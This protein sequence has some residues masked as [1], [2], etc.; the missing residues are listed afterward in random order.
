MLPSSV[1]LRL[2]PAARKQ[3]S[4]S[5]RMFYYPAV[6][7]DSPPVSGPAMMH[8][9][10]LLYAFLGFLF[11][12]GIID[13]RPTGKRDLEAPLAGASH[14]SGT[15]N[16][17]SH[18]ARS[19]IPQSLG[20]LLARRSLKSSRPGRL[21]GVS[22]PGGSLTRPKKKP[23]TIDET[24]S[25]AD[26]KGGGDEK[27]GNDEI[28]EGDEKDGGEED[29]AEKKDD[30]GKKDDAEKDEDIKEDK[31]KEK[32]KKPRPLK[33]AQ[34]KKLKA[35][36]EAEKKQQADEEKKK[37]EELKKQ[38]QQEKDAKRVKAQEEKDKEAQKVR[39][40]HF[41]DQKEQ[42]AA[43]GKEAE[44]KRAVAKAKVNVP[45]GVKATCGGS[46]V[47][48][49]AKLVEGI[50]DTLLR[51][52]ARKEKPGNQDDKEQPKKFGGVD[53]VASGGKLRDQ[54]TKCDTSKQLREWPIFSSNNIGDRFKPLEAGSQPGT[55]RVI[56]DED[57][58]YC[59]V[60]SHPSSKNGD[61]NSFVLCKGGN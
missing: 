48:K 51:L 59:G 58:Q 7:E 61:D 50:T 5:L 53:E 36:E 23:T 28:D 24:K 54:F 47:H 41:K 60:V 13:A 34:K 27:D 56:F 16:I 15:P 44:E 39:E 8:R 12:P 32:T 6:A 52:D 14:P 3:R 31:P 20:L 43:K 46:R 1:D 17:H 22:V 25:D 57:G 38:K 9:F 49:T 42:Q 35:Q 11:I 33:N 26:E 29:G 21:G 37:A 10:M 40:K 18:S 45:Q 2:I 55:D 4:P 30:E 19:L